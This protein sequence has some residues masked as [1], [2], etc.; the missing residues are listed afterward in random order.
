MAQAPPTPQAAAANIDN[1]S[2]QIYL[3]AA[4]DP[5]LGPLIKAIPPPP[6]VSS[7]FTGTFLQEIQQKLGQ[8]GATVPFDRYAGAQGSTR[9]QAEIPTTSTEGQII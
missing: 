1:V 6:K 4:K 2:Q 5:I 8:F 9:R 3:N 7:L